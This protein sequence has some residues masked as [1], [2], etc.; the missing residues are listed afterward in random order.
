MAL[1]I[2]PA[3]ADD[4]PAINGLLR[5]ALNV[6]DDRRYERFLE[7]KH[8]ANPFG[9]SYEWV[10]T[11]DG[12]VVGYRSFLR[13]ELIVDGAVR[14][15]VRAVDTATDR[16]HYGKG[17][18]NALTVQGV[19]HLA[20]EGVAW[21]FNTPNNASRPGYL[22]MGWSVVGRLPVAVMARSPLTLRHVR[23]ARQP[24]ARWS[25]PCTAF[26]PAIE[27]IGRVVGNDLPSRD[28]AND[29]WATN[30]TPSF[31]RWRY[32]L[33][34][35]HYRG[36]CPVADCVVVFRVRQ[37]GPLREAMIVDVIRRPGEVARVRLGS[38]VRKILRS[39]GADVAV[40]SGR[41]RPRTAI[42]VAG[43]QLTWRSV[44]DQRVPTLDQLSFCG[45]DMELF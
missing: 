31:L 20:S 32:G 37:R 33:D 1:D 6:G 17:I 21:V 24:A 39:T 4:R 43:P 27:A 22:K 12:A 7:W 18:F 28:A 19:E 42:P 38:V 23:Q 29:G 5:Q 10:A 34:D 3:A 13:W 35:L 15:A 40:I 41:H 16:D 44:S 26:E 30:R 45:G 25:E 11:I 36:V 2:R 14:T 8:R 9:P